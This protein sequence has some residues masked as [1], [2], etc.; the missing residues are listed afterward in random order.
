M[1]RAIRFLHLGELAF[2][3]GDALLSLL[4]GVKG[5]LEPGHPARQG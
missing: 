5:P 2:Q 3:T 1:T 4:E